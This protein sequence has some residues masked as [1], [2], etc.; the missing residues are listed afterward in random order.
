[1]TLQYS[2]VVVDIRNFSSHRFFLGNESKASMLT[3]FIK[4]FLDDAITSI[5]KIQ[6]A[7]FTLIK[8]LFNHT[9]DGFVLAVPG[10]KSPLIMLEWLSNFKKGAEVAIKEYQKELV[11]LFQIDPIARGHEL[12][13]R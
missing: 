6:K 12:S 8:P 2:V 4:N 13:S 7:R 5:W 9:G 10:K 1:M 11:E 3:G